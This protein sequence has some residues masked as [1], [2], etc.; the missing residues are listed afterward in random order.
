[1]EKGWFGRGSAEP[2]AV[3]QPALS[4]RQR[5][6]QSI[7]G[8]C[9]MRPLSPRIP[10]EPPEPQ[11]LHASCRSL[12]REQSRRGRSSMQLSIYSSDFNRLLERIKQETW[13][14]RSLLAAPSP[15]LLP[16]GLGGG[17]VPPR[18]QQLVSPPSELAAGGTFLFSA[19]F[20]ILSQHP[21]GLFPG[22]FLPPPAGF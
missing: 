4:R 7:P 11:E 1:M 20:C 21:L 14:C 22:F 12:C 16:A 13:H 15:R 9:W 6:G 18:W 10:L 2:L 19:T 17:E 3:L 8:G 5:H